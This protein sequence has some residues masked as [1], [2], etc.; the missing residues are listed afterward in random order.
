MAKY[1]CSTLTGNNIY[2]LWTKA[3]K[4]GNNLPRRERHVLVRGGSL[5][6]NKHIITP[7]G[8]VTPVTDE[9]LKLLEGCKAFNRHVAK[10]FIKV[11]D[12]DPQT[13]LKTAEV[14]KDLEEDKSKPVTPKQLKKEGKSEGSIGK[15]KE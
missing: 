13:P 3:A 6:A 4:G 14:A 11:L 9:E 8:V 1:I 15:P 12:K 10:G 5:V 7:H 2:P